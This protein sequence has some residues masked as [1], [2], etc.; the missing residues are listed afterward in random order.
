M[1][2]ACLEAHTYKKC[3]QGCS[4]QT[5]L[6]KKI[7]K[8]MERLKHSIRLQYIPARVQNVFLY[9]TTSANHPLQEIFKRN[10]DGQT[11]YIKGSVVIQV[12]YVRFWDYWLDN[13][14]IIF[15]AFLTN[16]YLSCMIVKLWQLSVCDQFMTK[17]LSL[18]LTAKSAGSRNRNVL[19]S[20][21]T[22]ASQHTCAAWSC[23]SLMTAEFT[24][25]ILVSLG[26]KVETS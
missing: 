8:M 6:L 1:K 7:R 21:L 23:S 14:N 25:F 26:L 12:H 10:S 20:A 22:Q 5:N 18:L 19:L 15:K 13:L 11:C 9:P 2:R 24:I 3:K 17:G 4:L 16:Q